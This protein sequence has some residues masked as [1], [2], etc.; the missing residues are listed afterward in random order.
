MT[1]TYWDR[2]NHTAQWFGDAYIGSN[3]T[4]RVVVL[5]S[6][7][8]SSWPGYSGG[9]VA[10]N[11]T[12]KWNGTSWD[13]RQHYPLD[14]S[15]RALVNAKGGVETNT[16]GAVQIEIVGTDGW[17][18]SANKNA[19]YHTTPILADMS[20]KAWALFGADL[21]DLCK[22][23]GVPFKFPYKFTSWA[24]ATNRLTGAQWLAA[25]GIVGHCHVPE[26]DHTDPG[27]IPIA[28]IL[29]GGGTTNTST[30]LELTMSQYDDIMKELKA[31]HA[32]THYDAGVTQKSVASVGAAISGVK[33]PRTGKSWTLKD[34]MWSIWYYI[35]ENRDRIAALE[36]K[37]GA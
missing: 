37:L 4:P 24:N 26:N 13:W 7:E 22:V 33:N 5:H 20:D 11:L 36:K 29:A 8:G 35:L 12:A 25:S 34:A 10:P 2:A 21:A 32:Q 3:I 18:T 1:S 16:A 27:L 17:A 6:T 23:L 15:S 28:A 31:I 30:E 19:P 14:R 9:A